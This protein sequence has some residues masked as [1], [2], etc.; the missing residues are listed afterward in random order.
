MCYTTDE[1]KSRE[2]REW[3]FT[4]LAGRSASLSDRQRAGLTDWSPNSLR[5]S[6]ASYAL[7]KWNDAAKL[8]LELG[9]RNPDLLFAHYRALVTPKAAKA[10]WSIVPHNS[11][12]I[13]ALAG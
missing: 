1:M 4:A 7:S 9:H 5:H 10:F 12:K 11:N 3:S 8:S 13:V 6:F 2:G